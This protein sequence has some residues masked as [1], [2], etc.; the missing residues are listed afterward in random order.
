MDGMKDKGFDSF[1]TCAGKLE[2]Q[3][4][5]L[6][7]KP[8]EEPEANVS[9][10]TEIE[11]LPVDRYFDALEGPELDTLGATEDIVLPDDKLWPFLLRFPISSFGSSNQFLPGYQWL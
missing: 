1:K 9:Q 7:G 5:N 11:A 6:H 3:I 8:Q 4:S 2:R 10:S